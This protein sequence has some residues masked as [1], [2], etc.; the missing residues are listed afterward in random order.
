MMTISFE[1]SGSGPTILD[2]VEGEG[3]GALTLV[4]VE[5]ALHVKPKF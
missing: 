4:A 3:L 1:L 2:A 5:F